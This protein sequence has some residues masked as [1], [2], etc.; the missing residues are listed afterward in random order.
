[1]KSGDLKPAQVE[2]LHATVDRHRRFLERL[3]ARCVELDGPADSPLR[4]EARLA[5]LAYRA[6]AL[7]AND[8][9][10]EGV[11]RDY[12]DRAAAWPAA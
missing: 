10:P 4:R 9:R 12:L 6:L 11:R 7:A 8:G 3:H 1:M 2:A 5:V